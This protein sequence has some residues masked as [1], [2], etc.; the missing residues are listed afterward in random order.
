[1]KKNPVSR[2]P[3]RVRAGLFLTAGVFILAACLGYLLGGTLTPDLLPMEPGGPEVRVE[4]IHKTD[5]G[6]TLSVNGSFEITAAPQDRRGREVQLRSGHGRGTIRV[7]PTPKGLRL[8]LPDGPEGGEPMP[9]RLCLQGPGLRIPPR[10][11]PVWGIIQVEWTAPGKLIAFHVLD[12]ETYLQGVLLPEMGPKF[13]L[14]ALKAQA[15]AARSYAL[16]RIRKARKKGRER[17]L[18]AS[19]LDQVFRP[20]DPVPAPIRNA[21]NQTRGEILGTLDHPLK[22]YFHSTCGGATRKAAPHFDPRCPIQGRPCTFCSASKYFSW[23][24]RYGRAALTRAFQDAGLALTPPVRGL[25]P[26]E[27]DASGRTVALS[28][29][30]AGGTT[31][32]EAGRFR[33][34]VNRR[35]AKN[36]SEQL[37]SIYLTGFT[38][39]PNFSHLVITGQGWGH[40]VGMCQMGASRLAR[41][42]KSYREILAYYYQG[43][44]VNRAWGKS[45]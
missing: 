5:Q 32:L 39:S 10:Q 11:K 30:H 37:L 16:A 7:R 36:R 13:P 24:R 43:I 8:D 9:A 29:T 12:M 22:A 44:P 38:W 34:L 1:M 31:R 26:V 42:G 40:G 25:S 27:T 4:W 28:I 18:K 35:I 2:P 23:S 41:M 6:L 21:V 3:L 17:I 15:V 19:D 33:S 20:A 45:D 14:E